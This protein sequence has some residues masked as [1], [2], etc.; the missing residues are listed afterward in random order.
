MHPIKY[1]LLESKFSRQVRKLAK[2]SLL[3]EIF[4]EDVDVVVKGTTVQYL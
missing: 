2:Y 3:T 1:L 4:A